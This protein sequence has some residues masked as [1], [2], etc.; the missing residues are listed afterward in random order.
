V[1]AISV[2]PQQASEHFGWLG[3]VLAAD[4][5]ASSAL[6]RQ[7]VSWQPVQPGLIDDLDKRHYFDA[8]A[9]S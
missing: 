2:P 7:Q 4:I 3:M 6:T 1:P 9:A 8:P 5:P